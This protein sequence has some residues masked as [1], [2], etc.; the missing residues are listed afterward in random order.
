MQ[1]YVG[2]CPQFDALIEK[3]TV[4]ETLVMYARI[5]GIEEGSID[6]EVERL[7]TKLLLTPHTKKL[8]GNLR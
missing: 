6:D 5:R 2:Y 1:Q 3:L 8:S 4:R 7:I